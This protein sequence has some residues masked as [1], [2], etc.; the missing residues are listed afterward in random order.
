MLAVSPFQY[1]LATNSTSTG[2]TNFNVATTEPSGAGIIKFNSYGIGNSEN[3]PK[4]VQLI[5][6]GTDG[7]NDTFDMRVYGYSPTL[8]NSGL[9]TKTAMWIPQLLLDVSVVLGARTFSGHA[10]NTV[11]ADT[12]TVNGGPADNAEW[13]SLIDC[14]EDL[15]ASV[16]VHTRGCPIICFDWDL[17][18]GQEAVSMNCL[19][20]AFSG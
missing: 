9:V 3:V 8:A 1:A 18:G 11:L 16:L 4:Y 10:D 2:F 13:R 15:V 7:S 20:R 17:S 12:L 5:P 6:F 19:W 14:Q